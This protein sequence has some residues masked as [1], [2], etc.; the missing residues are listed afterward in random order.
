MIVMITGHIT[1]LKPRTVS[2]STVPAPTTSSPITS[3]LEEAMAAMEALKL[4]REAVERV[5]K[6]EEQDRAQAAGKPSVV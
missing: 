3:T 2:V 1:N 4:Y 5:R 6:V